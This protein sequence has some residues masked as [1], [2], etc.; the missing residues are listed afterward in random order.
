MYK[1][2]G[3][4]VLMVVMAVS[5]VFAQGTQESKASEKIVLRMGDNIPDRSTGWGAVI[6]KINAEFIAAHPGV[7]ITTESYQ[8]QAWQEKVKI[9]ATAN[10]LPDVMKYWS[11][12]T[13]LQPL[14]D[15]KFVEPLNMDVFK[16]Y[17]YMAGALE[18]NIYNG[19]LYGIPVSA[20]LWVIYVNKALFAKAGVPL[21]KTWEDI[22]ASVPKFKAQGIIPMVTDGKDGWPLCEM[23]DNIQQRISGSFQP[24]AD[25][26]DRKAKYTDPNFLETARYIQNL[27]KAGVFQSDLVTSDYGA[28][29]NLF[30]QER[31]AMYMM[32]VQPCI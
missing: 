10:Q 11:F 9:Y 12:S 27:V 20:D 6:E 21:P 13:L 8:D 1:K 23:F 2:I 4:I 30:G 3:L 15:G 16:Q 22:V 28:S 19:Q 18:G 29:R 26:I 25:A 32:G 7:E 14:V 24:V 31:A 17:G 5:L